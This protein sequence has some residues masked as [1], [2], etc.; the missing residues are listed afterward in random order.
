MSELQLR[1]YDVAISLR[2]T[3]VD[4]ARALYDLLRDR[5]EV[6]FADDRQEEFVGTDGEES[7]GHIFRY[8]TRLVV[9]FYRAAG[10]PRLSLGRRKL[11]SN[12]AL[13]EKGT[14]FPFGYRWAKQKSPLHSLN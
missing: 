5:M 8:Q 13:G 10:E 9:V 11:R 2:W 14:G 3:D 1:K 6:F 12:S 4:H 7:F